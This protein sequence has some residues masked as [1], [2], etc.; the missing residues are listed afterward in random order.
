M[1]RFLLSCINSSSL[2]VLKHNCGGN[3]WANCESNFRSNKKKLMHC[4]QVRQFVQAASG[5]DRAGSSCWPANRQ[6]LEGN[7]VWEEKSSADWL[8]GRLPLIL[9]WLSILG[10]KLYEEE[11]QPCICCPELLL[12]RTALASFRMC[13]LYCQG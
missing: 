7:P 12:V 3:D 2:K 6:H 10:R 4:I 13:V 1:G 5:Y 8:T 11:K 9:E